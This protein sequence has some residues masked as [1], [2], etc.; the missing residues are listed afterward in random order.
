MGT[1]KEKALEGDLFSQRGPRD[2]S[3]EGES[4]LRRLMKVRRKPRG[5]RVEVEANYMQVVAL[6]SLFEKVTF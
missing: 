4:F 1:P 5:Q 2:L 6:P 3:C